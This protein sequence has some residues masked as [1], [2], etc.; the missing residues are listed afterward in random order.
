MTDESPAA[1]IRVAMRRPAI[2]WSILA[3]WY[4]VTA[5]VMTLSFMRTHRPLSVV[6]EF[7]YIDAVDKARR[8][9]VVL[10]G[11]KTDQYA[12]ILAA[13]R[14]AGADPNLTIYEGACGPYVPDAET[15]IQG[16]NSADIHSPAYFFLTAWTSWPIERLLGVELLT[17]ARLTSLVWLWLGMLAFGWALSRMGARNGLLWALPVA[18]VAMPV[19]RGTNAYV[20]PD[21]LN[22]LAG[23]LILMS[24]I[25]YV[26]GEWKPWPFMAISVIFCLVK[27]QNLFAV[28][29]ALLFIYCY[30]VASRLEANK[31]GD[32]RDDVLHVLRIRD[33][34]AITVIPIAASMVWIIIRRFVGVHVNR[35]A[36]DPPADLSVAQIVYAVDDTLGVIF[37]GTGGPGVVSRAS[38]FPSFLLWMLVAGVVATAMFDGKTS[39]AERV[40]ARS[41]IVSIV[42]IGPMIILFFGMVFG[43]NVSVLYRYV[44]VLIPLLAFPLANRLTGR[45]AQTL[46]IVFALLAVVYATAFGFIN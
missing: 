23:S 25:L 18:V 36:L 22:L 39:L 27:F 11:D 16:Y 43:A 13:C 26:Q 34:I 40:L 21:A 41:A 35:P 3:G 32:S 24:A 45:V 42:A 19:F 17:A 7:Q 2:Y 6:D 33:I 14:G 28:A 30:A 1:R 10:P 5:A 15:F 46:M 37:A 8:W 12:R 4:A 38:M 20:T 29:A 44:M 31:V 9:D